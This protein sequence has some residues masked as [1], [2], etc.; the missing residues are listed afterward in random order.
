MKLRE[1]LNYLPGDIARKVLMQNASGVMIMMAVDKGKVI[2][3]HTAAA[4]VLVN[5]I[6]GECEFTLE[7]QTVVMTEGDFLT[8]KPG[9][10]HSLR[11]PERFKVVVTKLNI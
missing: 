6:E 3:T 10:Q 2:P 9:Q 5:V 11:A 8:M 4:D 1:Q 7:G